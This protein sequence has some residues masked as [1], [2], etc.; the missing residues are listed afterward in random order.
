MHFCFS[1]F[2]A[3]GFFRRLLMF[4]SASCLSLLWVSS[5]FASCRFD[6]PESQFN[7][8]QATPYSL[9][10]HSFSIKIECD[11]ANAPWQF[12][13]QSLFQSTRS[14]SAVA[15]I[16]KGE[17]LLYETTPIKG[18]GST[19]LDLILYIGQAKNPESA[20]LGY[21]YLDPLSSAGRFNFN[22]SLKLDF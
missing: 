7:L 13:A 3:T 12:M 19:T 4:F 21:G 14:E 9:I 11:Q 2:K 17:E 10:K 5:S 8:N 6:K 1:A 20:K 18:L 22:L 15:L 16:Y